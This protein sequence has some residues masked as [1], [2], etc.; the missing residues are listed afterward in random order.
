MKGLR[1]I[2]SNWRDFDNLP[3]ITKGKKSFVLKAV[4][5]NCQVY[6]L[7]SED[8]RSD[9][10]ILIA[11]L[12]DRS[13]RNYSPL[14]DAPEALCDDVE[15]IRNAIKV[16]LRDF[17]YAS[18]RILKSPRALRDLIE[19]NSE[20]FVHLDDSMRANREVALAAVK[21]RGGHLYNAADNI[22]SDREVVIAALMCSGISCCPLEYASD[23]LRN[24][25]ELVELAIKR[26][27]G[28]ALSAA[29]PRLN[30]DPALLRL[31]LKF[32]VGNFFR[33]FPE[34]VK[35]D[36]KLCLLAVQ[37]SS[38]AF[39]DVIES[40]RQDVDFCIA[41]VRMNPNVLPFVPSKIKA[42]K[43]F[44]ESTSPIQG[45]QPEQ[46]RSAFI[47]AF[48]TYEEKG[49]LSGRGHIP[50]V[51]LNRKTAAS[52]RGVE[53][54]RVYISGY[55]ANW[56]YPQSLVKKAASILKVKVWELTG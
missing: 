21:I 29:S 28:A 10:D 55:G 51:T 22:K 20:L 7:L 19:A 17:E 16:R 54:P 34:H 4:A 18:E 46:I 48:R 33:E 47:A 8:L 12:S 44:R 35:S 1:T 13:Y 14:K 32:G 23:K 52:L 25:R 24:D 40:L 56:H 27:G 3:A 2:A 38:I 53:L 15:V 50:R 30:S 11:A 49:S 37:H 31:A 26:F 41:A 6:S 45:P 36:K 39:E 43:L 5:Q 9:K 42:R